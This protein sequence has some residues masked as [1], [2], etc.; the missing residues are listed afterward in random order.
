[1]HVNLVLGALRCLHYHGPVKV[2]NEDGLAEVLVSNWDHT[3][4]QGLVRMTFGYD[5]SIVF[6]LFLNILI[7]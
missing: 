4:I 6:V 5:F 3:D 7:L 1:M 2:S